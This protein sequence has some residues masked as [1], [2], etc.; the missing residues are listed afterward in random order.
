VPGVDVDLD[1][2]PGAQRGPAFIAGVDAHAQRNALHDLDPVAAGVL[3]RQ[4]LKLLRCCRAD[5]LDRAVPFQIRIRVHVYRDQLAGQY[6]R[7]FGLFRIRIDPDVISG[8]EVKG[9]GRGLKV[10]AWRDRWKS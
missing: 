4:K 7:Q 5:A 3:R 10:F 9:S 6:M 8:D 1:T 2:H